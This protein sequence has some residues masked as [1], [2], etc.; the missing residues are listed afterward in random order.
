[1]N[2]KLYVMG[3]AAAAL[4]VAGSAQAAGSRYAEPGQPIAYGKLNSYM[5]ASPSKR[6][7]GDWTNTA[8]AGSMPMA[9]T[10]SAAD[11]A[12]TMPA[13]SAPTSAMDTPM[14]STPQP[15]GDHVNNPPS[16]SD[17][18]APMQTPAPADASGQTDGSS[19]GG[20]T[21]NTNTMGK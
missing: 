11:T 16:T 20:A 12:A 21:A 5:K 18:N 6:A 2:T 7:S 9:S 8:A 13:S 1:M 17:A 10:G 14:P 3:A 19:N 4:L 15:A